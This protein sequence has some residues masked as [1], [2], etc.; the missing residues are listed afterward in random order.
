MK[1]TKDEWQAGVLRV[2]MDLLE[3]AKGIGAGPDDVVQAVVG[4]QISDKA[5]LFRREYGRAILPL[6]QGQG[7]GVAV[8]LTRMVSGYY[9][10]EETL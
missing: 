1:M 2:S 8:E 3:Y 9:C 6:T 10:Q 7:I 4:P 5:T